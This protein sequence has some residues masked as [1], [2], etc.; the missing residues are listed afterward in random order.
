MPYFIAST[1]LFILA[2]IIIYW[3]HS[4][5]HLDI[6]VTPTPPPAAGA[7]LIS[8]CI[9]ARNEENNIRKCVEAALAQDYPNIEVIV[10]DDRSTDATA[11]ILR[12][13]LLESVGLL[14]DSQE[15]APVF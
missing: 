13:I 11:E 10:L 4:Q 2:L 7:A 8:I 5:Y 6:V 9:P 3:I 12:D 15:Q 1:I 14:S